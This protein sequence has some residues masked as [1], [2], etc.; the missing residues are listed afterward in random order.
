MRYSRLKVHRGAAPLLYADREAY[1][2]AVA[3]LL[4]G[5]PEISDS[6]VVRDVR[7]APS[8]CARKQH[9]PRVEWGRMGSGR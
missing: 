7:E 2:A 4:E 5:Q 3:E 1:Y 9:P 6:T 8:R